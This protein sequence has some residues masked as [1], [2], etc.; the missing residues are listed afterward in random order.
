MWVLGVGEG[1]G[2]G[3]CMEMLVWVG[4]WLGVGVLVWV[5]VL[6]RG[7]SVCVGGVGM[8]VEVACGWIILGFVVAKS[9]CTAFSSN[10]Q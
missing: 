9:G 5:W 3:L 10:I 4:V 1:W 8:R 7:V 6:V 2:V